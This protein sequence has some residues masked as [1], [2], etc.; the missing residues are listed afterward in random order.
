[1]MFLDDW[2]Q[3]LNISNSL[4]KQ[5]KPLLLW[6]F[7]IELGMHSS[8]LAKRTPATAGIA[9]IPGIGLGRVVRWV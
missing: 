6:W 1:M 8:N 3:S 5:K 7:L 4:F 2:Y 9:K